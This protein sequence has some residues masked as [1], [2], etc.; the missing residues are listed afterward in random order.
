M[1]LNPPNT[2]VVMF[3]LQFSAA[4]H[5]SRVNSAEITRDRF[6]QPAYEIFSINMLFNYSI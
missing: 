3:F 2:A 1:I 5:I 6:G 4:V